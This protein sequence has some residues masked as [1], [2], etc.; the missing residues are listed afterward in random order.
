MRALI[1]GGTGFCGRH[2]AQHCLDAGDEV[3]IAGRTP[4]SSPIPFVPVDITQPETIEAALQ[5][6][7]PEAIYHLAGLASVARSRSQPLDTYTTNVLGTSHVLEVTRR[8][9]PQARILVIGSA[10]EYGAIRP[11][12]LPLTEATPLR[13]RSPYGVSRVA[14]TLMALREAHDTSGLHVVATRT[15]NITGPGQS[16]TFICSDFARQMAIAKAQGRSHITLETGNLELRRDFSSI[17]DATTA[18]R[19]L[20]LKGQAGRAYNVCSGQAI[21]LS[22]LVSTLARIAKLEVTTR[23]D[24]QRLRGHEAPEIRGDPSALLSLLDTPPA[25]GNLELDLARLFHEWLES[26]STS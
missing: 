18:Y 26:V 4:T 5:A 21:P 3:T 17:R 16:P 7:R 12:D 13:P 2:L 1:L 11:E 6:T 19:C 25:P 22:Q 15:F 9:Q 24:P 14:S 10:E 8:L 23:T 20:L